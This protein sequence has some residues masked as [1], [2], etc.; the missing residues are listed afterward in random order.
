MPAEKT[1]WLRLNGQSSVGLCAPTPVKIR[2]VSRAGVHQSAHSGSEHPRLWRREH[3]LL[4][5]AEFASSAGGG[6]R[7]RQIYGDPLGVGQ[8][9]P[10]SGASHH[11]WPRRA[12]HQ[13]VPAPSRAAADGSAPPFP[14]ERRLLQPQKSPAVTRATMVSRSSVGQKMGH[15]I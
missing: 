1:R 13:S 7:K 14:P 3:A 11:R 6:A 5:D 2:R 12:H 9:D 8:T 15:K 10:I 4:S